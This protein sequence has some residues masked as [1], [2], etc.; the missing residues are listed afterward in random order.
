MGVPHPH[1]DTLSSL[2]RIIRGC[3]KSLWKEFPWIWHK[4]NITLGKCIVCNFIHSFT[5]IN[6]FCKSYLTSKWWQECISK[7]LSKL[8]GVATSLLNSCPV[9]SQRLSLQGCVC[10]TGRAAS[11]SL[12]FIFLLCWS[13]RHEKAML[14]AD[15]ISTDH[16][17]LN[18]L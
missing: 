16:P 18:V 11:L 1:H 14:S 13:S 3:D 12:Q 2:F 17:T 10:G 6:D 8:D 5:N 15:S 4:I 9:T 7:A